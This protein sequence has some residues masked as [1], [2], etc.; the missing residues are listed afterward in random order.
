MLLG[1]FW[2]GGVLPGVIGVL[3]YYLFQQFD[4]GCIFCN[5]RSFDLF[6]VLIDQLVEDEELFAAIA[7]FVVVM[8][9]VYMIRS[10]RVVSVL[11]RRSS[12][13]LSVISFYVCLLTIYS[14]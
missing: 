1:C 9:V 2:S 8:L 7:V 6:Q 13:G 14:S 10:L 5:D 4:Y 12:S 3:L 11:K